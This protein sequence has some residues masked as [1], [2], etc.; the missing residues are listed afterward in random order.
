MGI[1]LDISRGGILF[2][3]PYPIEPGLLVLAAT[4]LENNLIE[5]QGKLIY[6]VKATTGTY[7][8]GIKFVGIDKRVT[9]FITKLI[10][11]YNYQGYNLFIAIA[12]KIQNLE[13]NSTSGEP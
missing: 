6:S 5:V 9:T 7:H 13:S 8:S 4:D 12:R 1:T 11:G 10:K 2:E 3:T